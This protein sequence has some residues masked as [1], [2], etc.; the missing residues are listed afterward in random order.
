MSVNS[1]SV[2]FEA[3]LDFAAI[4]FTPFSR[5]FIISLDY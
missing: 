5:Q 3:S 1:S 4:I 2:F